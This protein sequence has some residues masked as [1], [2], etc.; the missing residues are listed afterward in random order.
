MHVTLPIYQKSHCVKYQLFEHERSSLEL[1]RPW[2]QDPETNKQT[3]KVN[4]KSVTCKK[5][6]M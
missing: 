4:D 1:I 5:Y 3:D 2:V 6:L